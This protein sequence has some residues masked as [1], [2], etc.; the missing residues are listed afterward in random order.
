MW[1]TST[2]S[3]S[4]AENIANIVKKLH[5]FIEFEELIIVK[6]TVHFQTEFL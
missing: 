1:I 2:A 5:I 6:S 4:K 3:K